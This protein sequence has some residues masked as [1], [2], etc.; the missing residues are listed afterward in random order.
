MSGDRR[1]WGSWAD[2]A[3]RSYLRGLEVSAEERIAWVEEMLAVAHAAGAL[4]KARD[5][6]G[7]PVATPGHAPAPRG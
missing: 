1:G 7:Q 4:P 5:A 6:W 2:A 3:E